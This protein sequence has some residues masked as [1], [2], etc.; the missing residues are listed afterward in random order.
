MGLEPRSLHVAWLMLHGH[1]SKP[2][3]HLDSNCCYNFNIDYH[4]VPCH[5]HIYDY[6]I[7]TFNLQKLVGVIDRY[8]SC[9]SIASLSSSVKELIVSLA[10]IGEQLADVETKAMVLVY[11]CTLRYVRVSSISITK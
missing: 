7:S 2:L 6:L 5:Y 11:K 10:S 1:G 4:F 8:Q 9:D 3:R